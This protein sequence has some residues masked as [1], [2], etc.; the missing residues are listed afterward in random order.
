[1]NV[2]IKSYIYQCVMD[3]GQV[4]FPQFYDNAFCKIKTTTLFHEFF[5]D[6]KNGIESFCCNFIVSIL[7]FNKCFYDGYIM[8][9]LGITASKKSVKYTISWVI[10]HNN[11]KIISDIV[12]H[13][14]HYLIFVR[15]SCMKDCNK[16][17]FV[18]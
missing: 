5:F 9:I 12:F 15:I 3:E 6:F 7:N 14:Y 8:N 10:C 13:F 4:L 17:Y 18:K 11:T 16:N 2:C 1:M